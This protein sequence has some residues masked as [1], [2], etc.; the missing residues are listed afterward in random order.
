MDLNCPLSSARVLVDVD[1]VR[2]TKQIEQKE[3]YSRDQTGDE[4]SVNQ[5]TY[6][7][8]PKTYTAECEQNRHIC[9]AYALVYTFVVH[10][11]TKYKS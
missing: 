2:Q 3:I 6:K 4:V 11:M 10:F 8:Q 1:Q 5:C 7:P 9:I